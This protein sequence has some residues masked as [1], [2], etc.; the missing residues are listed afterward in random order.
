VKTT[1]HCVSLVSL[2]LIV[3]AASAG[4]SNESLDL[5]GVKLSLGMK[6]DI[7]LKQLGNKSVQQEAGGDY[8]VVSQGDGG[9]TWLGSIY[10]ER[11]KATFIVKGWG[12]PGDRVAKDFMAQMTPPRTDCQ[13][14]LV[15]TLSSESPV[16]LTS[17]ICGPRRL[18]FQIAEDAKTGLHKCEVETLG[19]PENRLKDVGFWRY[20]GNP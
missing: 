3:M 10:F 20:C 18:L 13:F 5:G 8:W 17:L 12:S 15:Q 16:R 4:N 11:D 1:R 6:K 19:E 7:V 9:K 2:L 14:A